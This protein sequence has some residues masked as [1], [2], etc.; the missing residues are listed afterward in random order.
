[1]E[2]SELLRTSIGQNIFGQYFVKNP[3]TW[4]RIVLS[5][6]AQFII[7]VIKSALRVHTRVS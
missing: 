3:R 4:E 7:G 6:N 5:S 1:M 2:G